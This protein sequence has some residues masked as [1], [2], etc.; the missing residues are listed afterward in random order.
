M[1]KTRIVQ[2]ILVLKL[3]A[4]ILLATMI[5]W[6]N[7]TSRDL[8]T[9]ANPIVIILIALFSGLFW[10]LFTAL[11]AHDKLVRYANNGAT[12]APV[13]TTI[14]VQ[15]VLWLGLIGT[16]IAVGHTPG[17]VIWLPFYIWALAALNNLRRQA[18]KL[19]TAI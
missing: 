9:E 13:P 10:W 14:S 19:R 6:A 18:H 17:A 7:M 4:V 15:W 5:V 11:K 2:T 3:I 12:G 1:Q 8:A 16:I